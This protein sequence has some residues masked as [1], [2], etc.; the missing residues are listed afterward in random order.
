MR[1]V[2]EEQW[3]LQA[4]LAVAEAKTAALARELQ[5]SRRPSAL[6]P[7]QRDSVDTPGNSTKEF[8]PHAP[9][10]AVALTARGSQST[11]ERLAALVSPVGDASDVA[12][13]DGGE[14]AAAYTAELEA[15]VRRLEQHTH[16]L[17]S[18]KQQLQL[19]LDHRTGQ[20]AAAQERYTRLQS[21]QA[22]LE[23]DYRRAAEDVEEVVSLLVVARAAERAA[24]RRVEEMELALAAS[25]RCADALA[26]A[27]ASLD[28]P[29][30]GGAG[31]DRNGLGVGF[32]AAGAIQLASWRR[33]GP[34]GDN[35]SGAHDDGAEYDNDLV[36]SSSG[37]ASFME[38]ATE[39]G[40]VTPRP[41]S[42]RPLMGMAS[43]RTRSGGGG[44]RTH[45][46]TAS[47]T[48]RV[49]AS[50]AVVTPVHDSWATEGTGVSPSPPLLQPHSLPASP[51]VAL[52]ATLDA[53]VDDESEASTSAG[54]SG[55]HGEAA[56]ASL[57]ASTEGAAAGVAAAGVAAAGVA[58]ATPPSVGPP[59][60]PPLP[61]RELMQRRTMPRT[62][63]PTAGASQRTQRTQRGNEDDGNGLRSKQVGLPQPRRDA[64]DGASAPISAR[65]ASLSASSLLSPL[66]STVTALLTPRSLAQQRRQVQHQFHTLRSARGAEGERVEESELLRFRCTLLELEL[67]GKEA[68]HRA[69]REAWE[70]SVRHAEGVAGAMGEVEARVRQATAASE[71][72][73]GLLHEMSRLWASA[74]TL[75]DDEDSEDDLLGSLATPQLV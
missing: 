54:R 59:A 53:E 6:D 17:R 15:Y 75:D 58:A 35:R 28:G 64:A 39:Y 57:P 19:R 46:A 72:V 1:Q 10:P 69:E 13:A 30:R 73:K 74:L 37:F 60:V 16:A 63:T 23:G 7:T 45:S 20:L 4:Q 29:S 8:T 24:M 47:A 9:P 27:A 12:K 21:E 22:V 31:Q 40:A 43:S 68:A 61:L 34:H 52:A 49:G 11:E 36:P 32:T 55:G 14:R 67:Q 70:A 3:L 65:S 56:G 26:T 38:A 5:T 41:M 33:H 62:T 25:E 50:L 2:W 44:L 51:A 18:E 48:H 66:V 42:E 71:K